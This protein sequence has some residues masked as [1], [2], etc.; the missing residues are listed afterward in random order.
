MCDARAVI[1]LEIAVLL[2]LSDRH[3]PR[4]GWIC[5][6]L[7]RRKLSERWH[8][9]TT[10]GQAKYWCRNG[11]HRVQC[12]ALH[13]AL[14]RLIIRKARTAM[15]YDNR[16]ALSYRQKAKNCIIFLLSRCILKHT[17]INWRPWIQGHPR[18]PYDIL[19]CAGRLIQTHPAIMRVACAADRC[20]Y[21]AKQ[22]SRARNSRRRARKTKFD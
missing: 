19:V 8:L 15:R 14:V 2:Q 5:H 18:P 22:N 16:R 21:G 20:T 4:T 6:D 3:P 17:Q 11:S 13:N 9:G 10:D 1:M 7:C 12:Y